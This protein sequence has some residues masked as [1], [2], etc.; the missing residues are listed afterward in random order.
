MQLNRIM[1]GVLLGIVAQI[2][3]FLQLQGQMKYDA[4]RNNMWFLVLMGMPI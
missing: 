4:L 1:Y 3:T 2:I